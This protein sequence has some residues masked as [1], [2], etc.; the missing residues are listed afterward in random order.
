MK[1]TFTRCLAALAF[2]TFAS[3]AFAGEKIFTYDYHVKDLDNGL[4]VIIVPTDFP[5]I[6]SIQIPV[7]TG[8]RN[9]VEP[10]KSGFAHFFEHMM[11]RGTKNHSAEEYNEML[12]N[13]GADQNAYTT[14]DYTNYHIQFSK[15]DLETVLMLEADRFKN[16]HYSEDVFKTEARAVLGEYNKNYSAP[17]RKL[18]EAQR[19]AAYK[20]HTYKHTTM[21]FIE[22]IEDMPNEFEYSR[23]FFDRYY[24][25]EYT[26]VMLVGDLDPER[27]IGLVEKY[28]GDWEPGSYKAEIPVEPPPSGP[29]FEHVDWQSPTL[30][31]VTV[32]FHGPASTETDPDMPA[33]DLINNLHF[34]SSSPLFQKLVIKEQKVQFVFGSFPDRMDPG[35]LTVG[36][37][38]KNPADIWYVRDEI[39][40]ELA[41]ARAELVSAKRLDDMR[42]NLRY[43]AANAMVDSNA[44][45]SGLVGYVVRYRDVET[46]NRIYALYDAITPEMLRD[47]ANKYFTDDRMV[48]TTLAHGDLPETDDKIGSVDRWAEKARGEIPDIETL[49][50]QNSSPIVNF[51]VLFNVGSALDP[52]GKEGLASLTASMISGGGSQ[53]MSY[54]DIQEA[55][56]PMAAGFGSQVDKEM[57]VFTGQIHL[58][59]LNAYYDVISG[60]LLEPAWSEDDFN[61]IKTNTIN[62]IKVSLRGN[63]DE[64]LGKEVLYEQ[65]YAGHP[66][67]HLNLGHISAIEAITLDDVKAFY[68]EYYTRGNLVLGM[69]GGFN[70]DFV[71]RVKRDMG[72][73]PDGEKVQLK[74]P[75]PKSFSGLH[76]DIVQKETRAVGISMGFPIDVTRAHEDFPALWLIRSYFGEHRSSNSY[77]YQRIRKERG[78]NYGDYAYIEYFPGGMFSFY[79]SPNL[80]RQ[81]QIF[82]IWIRPVPPDNAHF[83][84]RIAKYELDKLLKEGLSQEDFE[85]TRNYLM[86]Y[87]NVLV[88]SQDRQLGYALDSRRYGAPEF[89]KHIREGLKSL[90][91]DEVNRVLRK[92][93][94]SDDLKVAIIAKNAEEL[95]D[96]ILSGEPSPIS[97][98]APKPELEAEDKVIATYPFKVKP[99]NLKIH[100]V[101]QVFN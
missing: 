88:R 6:V 47:M 70:D 40:K 7:Q 41:R 17:A 76:V 60:Q 36:A 50:I 37:L 2:A 8:S 3:A 53:S 69:A 22:D 74:L 68:E 56:F 58:D 77:L 100:P 93:L 21:G 1:M 89:T 46:V 43:S 25:P 91:L 101:E 12:K 85:A 86:K 52:A 66:Y 49:I 45:A 48:I 29:I 11:F 26:T 30:P 98:D 39:Q 96:K 32:A 33:M 10:G 67:G 90:T 64:E 75:E 79:P 78:M 82:Q 81:Q 35:L 97:Y 84:L 23:T 83:A 5:N 71:N 44:I 16:L 28:W 55:M 92:R 57:T 42:A 34:S 4:R 15:E 13:I 80:A 94:Q 54:E 18:F 24:R 61:R 87:V 31:W 95:R 63:N 73:L 99:E 65:I 72:A 9:E 20:K 27:A 62:N 14:D 38:V 19:D 51:R 59:N